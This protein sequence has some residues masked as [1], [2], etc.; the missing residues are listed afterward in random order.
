MEGLAAA[1]FS[2][3]G[4]L[5]T[6]KLI[7]KQQAEHSGRAEIRENARNHLDSIQVNETLWTME[8]VIEKYRERLG[9]YPGE[10]QDL[11]RAGLLRS[12]PVDPSGV[13]YGY[14][15][16]NG[17]IH[18]GAGSR[19]RYLSVPAAFRDSYL[20]KLEQWAA[21]QSVSEKAKASKAGT[22]PIR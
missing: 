8:F 5:E 18:L 17:N 21:S 2:R 3:G 9:R 1:G 22:Q 13:P 6:A 20:Q 16:S 15:P 4:E 11:V 14:E 7:W 19:V 10:L 12:V